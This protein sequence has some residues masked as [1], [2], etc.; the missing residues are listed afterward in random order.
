ML[1]LCDIE[2]RAL[3][4][5]YFVERTRTYVDVGHI[6]VAPGTPLDFARW[7]DTDNGAVLDLR[8]ELSLQEVEA[9]EKGVSDPGRALIVTV[10]AVMLVGIGT[11]P[12]V[13]AIDHAEELAAQ[14]HAKGYLDA[15]AALSDPNVQEGE[16]RARDLAHDIDF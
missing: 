9:I 4:L 15:L 5:G 6:G 8:G 3:A 11:L 12:V 1:R 13:S 2:A 16:A 14:L 10:A 7:R